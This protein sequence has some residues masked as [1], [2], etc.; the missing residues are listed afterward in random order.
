MD[1]D[2]TAKF[3]A[4]IS[5]MAAKMT[6][7]DKQMRGLG[8]AA[9]QASKSI[10][11]Q[12][13][14]AGKSMTDAGKK[15]TLGIT[16][17]LVGIGVIA[18]NTSKDF[19]VS[20]NTLG[21]VSGAAASE[22]EDLR[23]YAMQMGA[24][25]VFSAGEAAN[26][27]VDLAKSG[28]SPA[29]IQGGG[30]AATMAL[31]ATEGMA[32]TDA[33]VTVSNAMS[34]FGLE[35]GQAS[36]IADTL[37]GGANASTASVDSLTQALRQV[38]PG[39]VNAGLSLNDTV[40]VLAAFDA[41]GIKGSDAGTS[42]KTMLMRLVPSTDEAAEMMKKL[43]INFTNADGSF[44]SISEV[45]GIL[46]S[47]LGG[48][49]EAQRQQA[50]TTM[51]GSDATRA[52]TV[53]MTE[54][55]AGIQTYIDGTMKMGSAQELAD[56]RMSGL[57]GT[58][59]QLKG[60]LETAALVIGDVLSPVIQNVANFIKAAAD[61]FLA[62]PAPLQMS[63][64]AFGGLA[65]AMGPALI[66]TGQMVGAV[67][68]LMKAYQQMPFH[69]AK[70][71]GAVKAMNLAFLTNPVVLI[72][73]GIV[74]AAAGL[75]LAFKAI[76]DRSAELRK[77][78]SDVV[79]V[80]KTVAQT[81]LGNVV[82]A[83]QSLF[84]QTDKTTK[85]TQSLGDIFRT[86]AQV[87]GRVLAPIV[88][89]LGTYFRVM[90]N[91]INVVIKAV[92]IAATIFKMI[93][94]VIRVGLILAVEKAIEIFQALMNKLGPVGRFV[95]N[96]ASQ[97]GRAFS[98]IPQF[99]S[100]AFQSAVKFVENAINSAIGAVNFLIRA[101]NKIPFVTQIA[102]LEAFRF[103]GF[104]GSAEVASTAATELAKSA[105]DSHKS[106]TNLGTAAATTAND[107]DLNTES[108]K[109]GKDANEAWKKKLDEVIARIERLGEVGKSWTQFVAEANKPAFD[110]GSLEQWNYLTSNV[111]NAT[112][113]WNN[114][115]DNLPRLVT[116]KTVTR[117]ENLSTNLRESLGAALQQAQSNLA[118]AER[119]FDQFADSVSNSLTQ[120]ISFAEAWDT[121]SETGAG[122]MA[123]LQEQSNK[124]VEF[125]NNVKALIAAGLSEAALQQ[126][127][128]AGITAGNEIAKSLLAGGTT[129]ID[130]A[131]DI[132]ESAQLAA[133]EV[134]LLAAARYRQAGIDNATQQV[135]GIMSQIQTM[136]PQIM[137]VMDDL[138]RKMRRQVI[139]DVKVSQNA[140]N[141]DVYVS[142]HISEHVTKYVSEVK[143]DGERAMGGPVRARSLYLVGERGPEFFVPSRSGQIIPNQDI[144]RIPEPSTMPTARGGN[145]AAMGVGTVINLNVNAGMGA[146][147]AEVGRLVVD[148]LRQYER[149]NGPIPIAVN[150]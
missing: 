49:T 136:T 69:I 145:G 68:N 118:N 143:V 62:F 146:D 58:L 26:A 64:V 94:N 119:A 75:A 91:I 150:G 79:N 80:F 76:Y 30:L 93:G 95:Q 102:E 38:G 37:A 59:E 8:D 73:A 141:V 71:T 103:D 57:A 36:M 120:S 23:K 50:L 132:V 20:M 105:R 111:D 140:F 87:A 4:D 51:F 106:V 98:S 96:V 31:A 147:G 86:V 133:D 32:L 33:A 70:V 138:A 135:N 21:V 139:I 131:N 148:A 81:I 104:T 72:I 108:T 7:L 125:A 88:Q 123:A 56:A 14:S 78:V 126:V 117:L 39:A 90:G 42:L 15:M 99:I 10:S 12:L 24:D 89:A 149:R 74:A 61:R 28:F 114:F 22:V 35:A 115:A 5:D 83:F 127:L 121:G 113:A 9:G 97:I 65:A 100:S 44:K 19:E 129:T 27:M 29:Q 122:F 116:D 46:Q 47:R 34:T 128:S 16:A 67:G 66:I 1:M 41:A 77:A 25:T 55:A 101:Y 63:I 11:D 124:A 60:S 142:R 43:G 109:K 45:S 48:L 6:A 54:G 110:E 18:A 107:I 13:T 85:G 112:M 84:G 40:G 92:E 137:S 134:G 3:R 53:L 82:R 52:A 144:G 17:P 2:V 130:Q